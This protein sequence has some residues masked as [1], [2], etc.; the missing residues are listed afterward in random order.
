MRTLAVATAIG[1][2]ALFM[3]GLLF[4]I[5]NRQRRPPQESF[6]DSQ[7]RLKR[8]LSEMRRDQNSE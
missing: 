1:G 7:R 5:P 3:S 4:L 6:E 2:I 8:Y